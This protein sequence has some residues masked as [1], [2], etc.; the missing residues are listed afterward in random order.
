[1]TRPVRI[2]G[3]NSALL[4]V[5]PV[6]QEKCQD[7]RVVPFISILSKADVSECPGGAAVFLCDKVAE[8]RDMIKGTVCTFG[9]AMVASI[10]F[11]YCINLLKPS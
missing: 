8:L 10:L 1:M 7:G 4:P 5:E 2:S 11:L 6:R 9:Y 3:G